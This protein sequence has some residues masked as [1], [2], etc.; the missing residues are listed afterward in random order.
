MKY[1]KNR[2][3]LHPLLLAL[4]IILAS[5]SAGTC[6]DETEARSKATFYSMENLKA[7]PADSLTIFAVDTDTAVVYLKDYKVK[8]AEFPL[9]AE[10]TVCTFVVK[11]NGVNDTMS[12]KY[13]SNVHLI[14]KECGYTFYYK[15]DTIFFTRNI[16]DSVSVLRK[17]V[18]TLNE[19]N[20][21]IFY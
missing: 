4:M 17:T 13:S 9:F 8:G 5:C 14:S 1:K 16:I 18:T 15:L 11:I 6:F 3:I 20:I 10:D 19:E 2:I 12:Y 7:L 21:R